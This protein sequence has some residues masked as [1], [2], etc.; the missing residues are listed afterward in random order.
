M[1]GWRLATRLTL[2]LVLGSSGIATGLEKVV[3]DTGSGTDTEDDWKTGLGHDGGGED[4]D[5][6]ELE[7]RARLSCET[8]LK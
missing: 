3:T 1:I 2:K 4:G 6:G 7:S 8:V 5:E